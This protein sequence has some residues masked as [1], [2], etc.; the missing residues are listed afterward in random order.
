MQSLSSKTIIKLE[1]DFE[2]WK[3]E[4]SGQVVLR[5]GDPVTHLAIIK[6]GEF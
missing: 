3:A 5:E 6:S 1:L 2:E 4:K